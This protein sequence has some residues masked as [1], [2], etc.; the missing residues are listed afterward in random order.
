MQA[1]G[2]R[3]SARLCVNEDELFPF[4]IVSRSGGHRPPDVP[5]TGRRGRERRADVGIGP[6]GREGIKFVIARAGTARG[7]PSPIFNGFKWQ[8]ETTAIFNS[9]FS[10]FNFQREG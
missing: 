5:R 8:F 10:I 2:A 1:L 4:P 9:Q 7:N 6:Y 3:A